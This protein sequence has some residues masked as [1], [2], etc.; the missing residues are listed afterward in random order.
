MSDLASG[1]YPDSEEEWLLD[2]SPFPPYR[3]VAAL[4]RSD[5][6]TGSGGATIG[7]TNTLSVFP[8]PVQVGD[9]FNFVTLLVAVVGGTL[10]HSWIAL[11]NG[12][13]AGAALQAQSAD[14]TTATGWAVGAN[15]IALAS[16]VANI[17]TVGTPQGGGSP[18]V[19]PNGPAIWGLAV[20]QS[21]TTLNKFDGMPGGNAGAG[22]VALTGQAP[23]FSASGSI[24]ATGTAP[25]VLPAMTPGNGA[26]PYGLIS[27]Q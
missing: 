14:N 18:A 3:R 12:T 8:V 7:T 13:G 22:L 24:G 11:Y 16:T 10:A 19:T 15:K 1:R 2:G 9:I 21:G 26:V 20:Y 27:R 25:S 5:I 4:K 17:G 23:M 6:A